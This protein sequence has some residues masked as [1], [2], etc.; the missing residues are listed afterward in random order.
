MKQ[1]ARGGDEALGHAHQT[2]WRT[3]RLDQ[4]DI[5]V[6]FKA[7]IDST[8]CSV[9]F[10]RYKAAEGVVIELHRHGNTASRASTQ[11]I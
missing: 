10:E 5:R 11:H 2:F 9:K 3:L 1:R 8:E 7:R 4:Q 6:N